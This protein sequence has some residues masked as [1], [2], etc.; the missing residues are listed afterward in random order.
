MEYRSLGRT[1]VQVSPFCL[2]T[3]N[4]GNPINSNEANEIISL[5]ID[6]GINFINMTDVDYRGKS[7][8][9]VGE[10]LKAS[11]KRQ[12]VILSVEISGP[13]MRVPYE[14]NLSRW[15]ILQACDRS[16]QRLKSDYIDIYNIPRPNPKIPIDETLSVL[17]DL[18][19]V[20]KIRYIGTSV[21]PAWMIV[22]AILI[23]EK[24]GLARPIMEVSPYNLLD[25][26]IENELVPVVQK[27]DHG[28]ITWA[29]LGQGV[30]AG[31]YAGFPKLPAESRAARIGGKYLQRVTKRG[32]QLAEQL[33]QIA[34]QGGKSLPQFSYL[35][36]RDQPGV[37]APIVGIR[38]LSQLKELLPALEMQLTQD[39]RDEC[40]KISAPGTAVTNFFNSAPWM[41]M[42]IPN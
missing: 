21:F 34:L 42:Q 11:N 3:I 20:G 35:W 16:L 13:D 26:R 30:L 39:E 37:V 15:Y 40:D 25:R 36:A 27:Y 9:V 10:S 22:E 33:K 12:K 14:P 38:T 19:R 18:I 6:E 31:R 8:E 41:K 32:V 5:A 28:L 23:A 1:G 2:G 24:K 4:F 29:A 17:T 7:E